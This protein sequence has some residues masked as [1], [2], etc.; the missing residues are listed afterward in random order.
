VLTLLLQDGLHFSALATALTFLP[1]SLGLVLG[2]G[3]AMQL[4]PKLGRKLVIAGGSVMA[5]GVLLMLAAVARYG[6][7]LQGWQLAPGQVVAGLGMA[8]AGTTLINVVLARVPATEAGAASGLVNT[9]IYIGVAA[10]IALI[11]TIMFGLLGGGDTFVTAAT[12]TLWVSA[13][14]F[15]GSAALSFLLPPGRVQADQPHGPQ[16]AA[17]PEPTTQ[18]TA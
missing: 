5:L 15:I 4:V 7:A 16:A 8:L 10:G 17:H 18:E 3:A 6:D 2:S 14:L 9:A 13:G 11:G 1:F 12:R